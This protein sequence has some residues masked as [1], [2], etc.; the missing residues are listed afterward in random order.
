MRI[1]DWSSDVCSSDLLRRRMI[2]ARGLRL[3]FRFL[4]QVALA[5][6]EI[7]IP[8]QV[9]ANLPDPIFA[10]AIRRRNVVILGEALAHFVAVERDAR[11]RRGTRRLRLCLP[12][13][14]PRPPRP[15]GRHEGEEG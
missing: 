10:T 5:A 9:G 2:E 14:P 1:S 3:Q 6:P 15:E 12:A 8:A 13:P 4:D 7:E 11:S